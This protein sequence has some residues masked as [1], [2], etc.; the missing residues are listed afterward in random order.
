MPDDIVGWRGKHRP[1]VALSIVASVSWGTG[2]I[3]VLRRQVCSTRLLTVSLLDSGV[4]S[5]RSVSAVSSD[6]SIYLQK[7]A[8][9]LGLSAMLRG[10]FPRKELGSS[11]L[12]RSSPLFASPPPAC[13][14]RSARH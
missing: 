6:L 7:P 9:K 14:T 10:M 5:P 4:E 13:N 2:T 1:A 8:S 11:V 12:A 3:K